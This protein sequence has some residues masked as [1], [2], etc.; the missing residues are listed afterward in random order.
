MDNEL[1]VMGNTLA[2]GTVWWVGMIH[3]TAFTFITDHPLPITDDPSPITHHRT[4]D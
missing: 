1:W 3:Q 4:S 2:R